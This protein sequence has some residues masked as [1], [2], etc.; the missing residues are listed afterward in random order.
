MAS[1]GI[2]GGILGAAA[3]LGR[4][5][6]RRRSRDRDEWRASEHLWCPTNFAYLVII[7]TRESLQQYIDM[8]SNLFCKCTYLP[9]VGSYTTRCLI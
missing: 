4:R 9:T 6:G 3:S 2:R 1:L 8:V 7:A 5:I